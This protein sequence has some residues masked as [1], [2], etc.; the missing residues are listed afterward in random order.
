MLSPSGSDI[1]CTSPEPG[2]RV[3]GGGT[4]PLEFKC[5]TRG[6]VEPLRGV[7]GLGTRPLVLSDIDTLCVSSPTETMLEFMLCVLV[8]GELNGDLDCS[9]GSDSSIFVSCSMDSSTKNT[10]T[11]SSAVQSCACLHTCFAEN[12]SVVDGGVTQLLL[13]PP[14]IITRSRVCT[15]EQ[16][17]R[18]NAAAPAGYHRCQTSR[19]TK[20]VNMGTCHCNQP[21][22]LNQI[23]RS[24]S[25]ILR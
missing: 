18:G 14:N 19:A 20:G 22:Y 3:F 7:V 4:A 17:A 13:Y 23:K 6:L 15:N 12:A 1:D 21:P 2:V 5:T 11:T 8:L 16:A 24:R 25:E 9:V 10:G